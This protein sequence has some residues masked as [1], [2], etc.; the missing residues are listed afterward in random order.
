MKRKIAIALMGLGTLLVLLAVG[1]FLYNANESQSAKENSQKIMHSIQQKLEEDAL[2]KEENDISVEVDPF[3][4]EM[5]VVEIDGYGYIG[6]LTVPT[7]DL[8]LPVMSQWDYTRLTIA[9]CR[10][11]GSAKADNLV[12]A[13]HNYKYH[14]GYLGKLEIGDHV[15]F[16]DMDGASYHYQVISVEVLPPQ[17]VEQVKNSG[18]D[19][20][21]YT[22]TYSGSKRIVVRCAYTE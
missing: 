8:D 1:L 4:E 19:L 14:F 17:A 5:K 11:H 6:Y 20:V 2:Q 18:A 16:T 12:I 13:A 3:D 21:L 10:Y 22:C 9:P 15:S 7:L